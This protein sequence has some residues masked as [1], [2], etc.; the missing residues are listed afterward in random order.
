MEPFFLPFGPFFA[1]FI[2]FRHFSTVFGLLG[3][4]FDLFGHFLTFF[5][6]FFAFSPLFPLPLRPRHSPSRLPPPPLYSRPMK[7]N[8]REQAIEYLS[9][10][11]EQGITHVPASGKLAATH[12]AAPPRPPARGP[13]RAWGSR[14]C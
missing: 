1:F 10:L 7:K 13:R 12:A 3:A 4:F 5:G 14:C 2:F 9:Y 8:L 6:L 11:K